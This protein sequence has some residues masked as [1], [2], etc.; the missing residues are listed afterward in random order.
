MMWKEA[1]K[2]THAQAIS[3][4]RGTHGGAHGL[5]VPP[6]LPPFREAPITA[7]SSPQRASS[8]SL[9]RRCIIRWA[10]GLGQAV[11]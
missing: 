5:T 3:R 2:T 9:P 8:R 6:A 1:V 4:E 11:L 10:W 7:P